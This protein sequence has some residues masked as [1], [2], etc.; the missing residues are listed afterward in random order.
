[1]IILQATY[2]RANIRSGFNFAMFAVDD[3]FR[4]IKTT[5]IILQHFCL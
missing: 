2:K 3:F 5:E 1:M 4:E